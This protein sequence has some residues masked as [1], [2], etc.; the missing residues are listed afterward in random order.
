MQQ[1]KVYG[2]FKACKARDHAAT[3]IQSY[4]RGVKTREQ[5]AN[6]RKARLLLA[7]L[8][9]REAENEKRVRAASAKKLKS[10]EHDPRSANRAV[11]SAAR[12][13]LR[14]SYTSKHVY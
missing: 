13:R 12:S 2:E 14:S 10:P 1:R 4:Y 5:V 7:A 6:D 3:H 11:S 8:E 9:K